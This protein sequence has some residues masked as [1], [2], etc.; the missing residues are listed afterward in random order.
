VPLTADLELKQRALDRT[1]SPNSPPG[2]Y[3]PPDDVLA[4]LEGL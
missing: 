3:Q 4:F 2:R 1:A